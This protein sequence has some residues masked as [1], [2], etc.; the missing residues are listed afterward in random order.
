M[1]VRYPVRDQVAI[2]GVG[3]TPYSRDSGKSEMGLVVDAARAAIK[4]AGLTAKDV[5]GIAGT[6]VRAELAQAALGIPAVNYYLNTRLPPF[7]QQVVAGINAVFSG[8][9]DTMLVYHCAYRMGGTS[10]SAGGDP[11]R[12][13][14]RGMPRP[15]SPFPDTITGAACYASWANRYIEEY[16]ASREDLGRIAINNRTNA[17]HNEHA[18]ARKPLTMDEYLG[19]RMVR[20][21]LTVFDMDY[22]IDGADAFIITTAERARDLPQKP[23]IVHAAVLGQTDHGVEEDLPDLTDTGLK[24]A[25]DALW[26]RSEL[27]L[28]DVDVFMPYD[29]F[30]VITLKWFEAIGYCGVG[31]AP[32][33]VMDNWNEDA[34][35]IEIRGRVSVNPHGGSLSEGASQ[36]AGHMR[37]AVNQLRGQASGL[38]VEGART[39]LVAPGG[40]FYN[41]GAMLFRT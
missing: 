1:T 18:A 4:D 20:D 38:Q 7:S 8:L 12:V 13:S 29:G 35:R 25:A 36:S 33:F 6:W 27:T 22:T 19:A 30:S 14:R 10:R 40:F 5:D 41:A 15:L 3:T 34:D 9:C 21:P 37:E 31:E 26:A 32:G 23:V 24:V 17:G 39:A 2:V 16:G 11:F 28:D